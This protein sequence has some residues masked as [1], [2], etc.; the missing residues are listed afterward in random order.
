VWS[1][2][3]LGLAL[4]PATLDPQVAR[5]VADVSVYFAPV[6][7]VSIILL[8]APIGLA[9]WRGEGGFPRWLAWLTAVFALEQSI[10]TITVF[11]KSG[12]IAPGGAMN[13]TLGAGLLL[14]WVIA[15]GAAT[16]ST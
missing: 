1:W 7:T 9:A 13:F 6:L 2:F 15:A 12:F 11:G 5:T 4:H 16:A 8:I 14:V 10:E 3:N